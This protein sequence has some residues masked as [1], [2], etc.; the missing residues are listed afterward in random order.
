MGGWFNLQF[1]GSVLGLFLA[2]HCEKKGKRLACPTELGGD[3]HLFPRSLLLLTKWP[4]PYCSPQCCGWSHSILTRLRLWLQLV[5]MP[6]P[7]PAKQLYCPP[8]FAVKNVNNLTFHFTGACF[9][10][11]RNESFVALVQYFTLRDILFIIT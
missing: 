4:C 6:A 2:T 10:H 8:F 5:K 7:E 9:I 11:K 1:A 3:L